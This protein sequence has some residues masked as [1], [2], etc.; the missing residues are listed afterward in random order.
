MGNSAFELL[1]GLKGDTGVDGSSG[2]QG[3]TGS[4]G[5]QGDTGSGGGG[6]G[7]K[8]TVAVK[9]DNYNVTTGDVAKTLLMNSTASKSFYLP[10]VTGSDVGTWM[11]FGKINTGTT[12]IVANGVCTIADS[13]TGGTIYNALTN[14]TYADITLELATATSWQITGGNGL[15]VAT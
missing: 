14:E 2:Y 8:W 3:D 1:Q 12:T 10:A 4:Q 6:G 5:I 9:T 11:T 15:W 7:G 13:S